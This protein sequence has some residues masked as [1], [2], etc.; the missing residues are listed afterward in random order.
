M[1]S[2]KNQICKRLEYIMQTRLTPEIEK[3]KHHRGAAL[4][5]YIAIYLHCKKQIWSGYQKYKYG[6]TANYVNITGLFR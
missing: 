2:C 3:L 6:W 5:S 1:K 4:L